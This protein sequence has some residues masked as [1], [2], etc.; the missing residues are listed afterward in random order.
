VISKSRWWTFD[1]LSQ[2][3]EIVYPNNIPHILIDSLPEIFKL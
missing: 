1:E 3:N 2:T